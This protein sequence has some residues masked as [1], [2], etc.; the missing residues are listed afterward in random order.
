MTLVDS[1][2]WINHFRR[3]EPSL[4][5]L[6]DHKMAGIHP[7]I[8]GELACGNLKDRDETLRL[9]R[10]LPVL[11]AAN[12]REVYYLLETYGLWG[13]GLGWVDLHLLAA[14]AVTGWRLLTADAALN[15]AAAKVGIQTPR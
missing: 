10:D 2:V 12:E 13:T 3:P 11:R 4:I 9:L 15:K 5:Q 8:I 6:L 14:A 1:S 7:Y